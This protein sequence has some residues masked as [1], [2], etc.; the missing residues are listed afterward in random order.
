MHKK[1]P[2]PWIRRQICFE[3]W[4]YNSI[5]ILHAIGNTDSRQPT[6]MKKAFSGRWSMPSRV[7]GSKRRKR[8]FTP[9]L[10]F[11]QWWWSQVQFGTGGLNRLS[12]LE[13][14]FNLLTGEIP[15]ELADVDA[16]VPLDLGGSLSHTGF[17]LKW[18]ISAGSKFLGYTTIC[19]Q[20]PFLARVETRITAG[21]PPYSLTS[22]PRACGNAPSL[23]YAAR[24]GNNFT[25]AIL[26]GL[27]NL[28]RRNELIL[29]ANDLEGEIPEE[30]SGL[31]TLEHLS[32]VEGLQSEQNGRDVVARLRPM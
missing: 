9:V 20:A 22:I 14:G 18:A 19:A 25:G 12:D 27:G 23:R 11:A 31:V 8:K 5:T 26:P 6:W 29:D 32:L 16:L 15:S 21:A 30:L 24:P 13:L 2:G 7:A 10:C 28:V 17:R 4:R 3:K 1:S